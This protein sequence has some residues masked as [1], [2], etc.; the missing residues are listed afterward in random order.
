MIENNSY[1]G[2]QLCYCYP[3]ERSELNDLER[4]QAG[5]LVWFKS[6]GIVQASSKTMKPPVSLHF[7]PRE[8]E[9]KDKT[10]RAKV[11]FKTE[12]IG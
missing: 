3:H 5:Y 6:A 10:T 9:I 8:L 7:L 12:N 11:V 2:Q 1:Q 4:D